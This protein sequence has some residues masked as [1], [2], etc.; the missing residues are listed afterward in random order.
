MSLSPS[1]YA[2]SLELAQWTS[3][4]DDCASRLFN[5][6]RR[7]STLGPLFHWA[8][9]FSSDDGA[10]VFLKTGRFVVKTVT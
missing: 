2:T 4:V 5:W 3:V 1:Q 10:I 7:H 9:H 8:R 6:T